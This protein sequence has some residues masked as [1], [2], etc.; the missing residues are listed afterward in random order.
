LENHAQRVDKLLFVDMLFEFGL[1][2]YDDNR[3]FFFLKQ[4]S[5]GKFA[6]FTSTQGHLEFDW[7]LIESLFFFITIII[8]I[9]II[10]I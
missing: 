2:H 3:K 6:K 5:L 1:Y 7:N 10:K 8:Y 4:A 9:Y